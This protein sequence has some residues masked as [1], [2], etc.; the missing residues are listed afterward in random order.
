MS[1]NCWHKCFL[2][3]LGQE[4]LIVYNGMQLEENQTGWRSQC[5]RQPLHRQDQ[6]NVWKICVQQGGPE[7]WWISQRLHC[8]PSYSCF[9]MQLLWLKDSLLRN[10]MVLGIQDSS[11]RKR[12]L[13]DGDLNLKTCVDMCRAAEATSQRLKSLKIADETTA[14]ACSV[15]TQDRKLYRPDYST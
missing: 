15:S 1:G 14:E 13:Q 3:I 9:H 2:H 8:C 6:W 10:H 7:N 5:L 12:S 4:G 11:T